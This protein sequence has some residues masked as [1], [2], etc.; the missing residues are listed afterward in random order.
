MAKIIKGRYF[1]DTS[2]P[3]EE[4]GS[5]PSWGWRSIVSSK[6]LLIQGLRWQIGNG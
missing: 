6:D 1:Y 2:F 4:E 5:R 3:Q